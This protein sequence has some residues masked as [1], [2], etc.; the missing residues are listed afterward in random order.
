MLAALISVPLLILS[1]ILFYLSYQGFIPFELKWISVIPFML[2]VG[3]FVIRDGINEWWYSKHPPKL[4]P[5]ERSIL[6]RF[7]P[8][9]KAL[10][11]QLKQEFEDRLT[12]F[13]LQKKFQ[14]RF[15][16]KIPG[17]LQ[18]LV[19]ATGI[20]LTMGLPRDKEFLPNLGMI[21]L[22]PQKFITPEINTQLHHV[23]VNKD[24]YDC[25]LLSIDYFTKGL[26][27]PQ[28]FY[29]SGLHGMAKAFRL[30]K[31]ISETLP[32]KGSKEELLVQLHHLRQFKIGY[33]FQ[34]TGLGEMEIF[35]MATE[36]FFTYPDHFQKTLPEVYHYLQS[37]YQQ[38]PS[39]RANPRL[40][41]L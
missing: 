33:Q 3:T 20:Q 24:I 36:L 15:L 34:Y 7:F 14:M 10:N 21:V 2:G 41:P 5:K 25:L 37:H 17:D 30:Q 19:C 38:D 9:Y 12:V 11:D 35:E 6:T 32:Y 1:L 27:Q 16:E 28:N 13:S 26:R 8:Y 39:N 18:L 29:N 22:F 31:N 4:S 23:E 40:K